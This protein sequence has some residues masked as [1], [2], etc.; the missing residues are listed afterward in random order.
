MASYFDDLYRQYGLT[1]TAFQ[2]AERKY[3]WTEGLEKC[4]KCKNDVTD[5]QWYCSKC[6]Y[7]KKESEKKK[8]PKLDGYDWV[9]TD[10][11]KYGRYIRK[12]SKELFASVIIEDYKKQL[13]L[14]ALSMV[15]NQTL[16]FDKWG[17]GKTV[18]K[19]K[20]VSML[21]YGAPGTGKTLMGEAIAQYLGKSLQVVTASD[22]L[23]KYVGQSEQNIADI[24]SNAK[25]KVLL[26]DECDSL[27]NE[28]GN[29]RASWEVSQV[30]VLLHELEEFEGVSIFTTNH[31]RNLD[32]A[33]DRR[34]ALKVQF[35]LPNAELRAAIWQRMFPKEAPLAKDVQ[36]DLLAEFPIT[37][38][39]I[40]NAVLRAARI[41]AFR[42]SHEITFAI[43]KEALRQELHAL[44]DYDTS[45]ETIPDERTQ[46]KI[47]KPKK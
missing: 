30:N 11:Y 22:I 32:K 16:I 2:D 38:G 19:G 15:E 29:A 33:L 39:Y 1:P 23:D 27:L 36:W 20:G 12:P 9:V 21:F 10:E 24:F 7:G 26:F 35:E 8:P 42:N 40:K 4:P 47:Q 14:E 28:R 41:A 44:N 6:G 31:T 34:I 37:G 3:S 5:Y 45:R 43:I 17:F 25:D 13:V 18:E 46:I